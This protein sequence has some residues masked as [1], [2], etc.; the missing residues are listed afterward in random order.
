[1]SKARYAARAAVVDLAKNKIL[2]G[3]LSST[4]AAPNLDDLAKQ[5]SDAANALAA[6]GYRVHSIMPITLPTNS[7]DV[8]ENIHGG[9]TR[10]ALV[11]GELD[12]P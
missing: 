8:G 3:M 12:H 11:L 9:C 4:L 5:V 2:G 7:K 10:G 6:D 1:V